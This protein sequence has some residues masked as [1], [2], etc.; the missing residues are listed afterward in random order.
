[1]DIKSG[2]LSIGEMAKLTGVGIQALRYY[3]RKNILKPVYVDPHSG[4]RYYAF[5]Q[6]N[7]IDVISACVEQ[8]I[9][10]RE[11]ADLFESEDYTLL[12][13]FL[14]RNRDEAKKKLRAIYTMIS[15]ADKAL[16]R[17]EQNKL[18]G[19]GEILKRAIPEKVYYVKT[20]GQSI[21]NANRMKLLIDFTEEAKADLMKHINIT[22]HD[23]ALVLMEYGFLCRYSPTGTEYFTFAEVPKYLVGERTITIASGSYYFR[24]SYA[25]EIENAPSIFKHKLGENECFMVVEVEEIFS[26]KTKINE[27]LYDL[28]LITT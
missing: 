11:L 3:E 17:M 23:E 5:E 27:P 6:A 2:L 20:C 1:M 13:K 15:L 14:E 12:K 28:R 10:L 8:D 9:P 26:G 4:Y 19:I 18:Y 16:K 21:E 24:K 22:D 7:S 25:S